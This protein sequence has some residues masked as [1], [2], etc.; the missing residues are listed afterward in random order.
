[1][2][3]FEPAIRDVFA[4]AVARPTKPW[5]LYRDQH[6]QAKY[7][8]QAALL[9]EREIDV[10]LV[11]TVPCHPT[12]AEMEADPVALNARLGLFTHFGNVLDL[13]GVAVSAGFYDEQ[14]EKLPFGVTVVGGSGMDGQGI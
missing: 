11:P 7:T 12:V 5:E 2:S 6:L 13:C 3:N 10:L 9:F 8:R 1:M 4:A 14:G